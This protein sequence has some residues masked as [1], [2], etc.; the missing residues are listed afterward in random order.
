M[1]W[2]PPLGQNYAKQDPVMYGVEFEIVFLAKGPRTV[3][4]QYGL[5]WLSPCHL[6]F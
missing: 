1:V 3:S 6:R 5:D 2:S 4:V